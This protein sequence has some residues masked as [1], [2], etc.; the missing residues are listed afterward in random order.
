MDQIQLPP[1]HSMPYD[2]FESPS[3]RQSLQGDVILPNEPG[4]QKAKARWALNAER[5]AQVI[6]FP[7]DASDIGKAIAH[8]KLHGLELAIRGGG[9]STGGASSTEGLVI[10]LSR[11]INTVE[12]DSEKKL[13]YVGGGCTWQQ[14]DEAA[15]QH[16]LAT[17]GGTVNH[18]GL[19]LHPAR[20]Y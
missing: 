3:L 15:I 5:D 7:K 19:I 16:G 6:V 9:H 4:Y 8:A 2:D 12:V 10:D 13:A 17:V 14:V 20:G 11:Y 18:V 1:L